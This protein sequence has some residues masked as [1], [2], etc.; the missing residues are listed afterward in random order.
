MRLE[1]KILLDKKGI[2]QAQL[3]DAAGVS[4]PFMSYIVKGYKLPSVTVAKRMADY[5][6]MSI[7]ELLEVLETK[8]A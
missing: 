2:T 5:L 8:S 1:F 4:Q 6:D 3:A 7:D